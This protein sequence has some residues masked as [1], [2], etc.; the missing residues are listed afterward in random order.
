MTQKP[1]TMSVDRFNEL[2]DYLDPVTI[3]ADIPE[4]G[5]IITFKINVPFTTKEEKSK[6]EAIIRQKS[7]KWDG[8]SFKT[9]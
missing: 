1:D 9:C 5:D 4:G 8:K 3:S 2:R 7:F 6:V